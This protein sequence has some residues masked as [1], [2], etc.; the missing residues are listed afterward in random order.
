MQQWP[1][2]AV[3]WRI[4]GAMNEQMTHHFIRWVS[5]ERA[6][7]A[8]ETWL[9]YIDGMLISIA[10]TQLVCLDVSP[11]IGCTQLLLLV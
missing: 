5:S 6:Q 4:S 2:A 3:G 7:Q 8:G 10:I 11:L 9:C 1:G